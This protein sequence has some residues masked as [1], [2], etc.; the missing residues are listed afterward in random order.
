LH[1][2]Y[3]PFAIPF[4]LFQT[5]FRPKTCVNEIQ[6]ADYQSLEKIVKIAYLRP[7]GLLVANV[8]SRE[9]ENE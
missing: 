5:Y 3:G 8:A 2:N 4:G 6:T 9:G 7:I 1:R